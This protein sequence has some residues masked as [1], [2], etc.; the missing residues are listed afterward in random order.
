MAN[1]VFQGK[2]EGFPEISVDYFL[3]G[4]LLCQSFFLG[5]CHTDH[6]K[7]LDS[8]ELKSLLQSKKVK[9]YCTQV[10][11]SLVLRRSKLEY[12]SSSFA[13]LEKDETYTLRVSENETINVTITKA[14]HCPGSVMFLFSRGDKTVLHTGDFCVPAD[15]SIHEALE[16]R[17]F[18]SLYMDTTLQ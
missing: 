9:T 7:G 17:H 5:H 1:D 6:I 18:D 12:L 15:F 14:H 16:G 10:T 2:V 8:Q 11:A 13:Y 4:S 3:G